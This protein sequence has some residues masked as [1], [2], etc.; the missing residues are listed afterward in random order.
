[1]IFQNLL[2]T[3][4]G[5]CYEFSKHYK[6]TDP[7]ILIAGT[8]WID[9]YHLMSTFKSNI[10]VDPLKLI[11]VAYSIHETDRNPFNYCS[12]S[13]EVLEALTENCTHIT[14]PSGQP[15]C[16]FLIF[17]RGVLTNY[18]SKRGGGPH[19]PLDAICFLLERK[20]DSYTNYLQDVRRYGLTVVS[21][22]DKRELMEYLMNNDDKEYSAV[23]QNAELP[24]PLM[25]FPESPE[26]VRE[27][28]QKAAHVKKR[29]A[30]EQ[31]V[32]GTEGGEEEELEFKS[33]KTS[34]GTIVDN[35]HVRPVQTTEALFHSDKV[36][37]GIIYLLIPHFL[38]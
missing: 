15:S 33:T 37:K 32:V 28:E 12:S 20:D 13:G 18:R 1:M 21:L 25:L 24:V 26:A 7:R 11:R 5:L 4:I 27:Q 35:L 29:P 2:S 3:L 31:K 6:G 36:K 10:P 14:I 8:G 9:F 30:K 34:T 17:P 23:D 19:Y 16:P 22:P 38:L